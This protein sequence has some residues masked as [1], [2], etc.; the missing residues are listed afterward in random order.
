MI[1]HSIIALTL[2]AAVHATPPNIILIMADDL[3][4]GD[5]GCY[6]QKAI[7]TPRLDRMAAEG[8]KFTQF[9]AGSTVCAPSRSVLM[10]GLHTG[11]T[12]V[13]GNASK[14]AGVKGLGGAT[15]RVPLNDEDVTIAEVLK[16]AGYVTG[17]TG[18]WGLGE[19]GTSGEP[20]AQGFD[21]WFG[22][23][24]QRRAHNHY[25]DYL[26]KNRERV[27]MPE[28][29]KAEKNY[30]HDRFT[31]FALDFVRRHR[32]QPFFLYLPYCVPHDHYQLPPDDLR[33]MDRDW[34]KDEKSHAEMVTR[35]DRDVGRLLDLL[36]ELKLSERT[37]VFFC[38]DNGAAR[39]WEGRFDSS[40][41]LRGRKRDLTEGGLRSPMIVRWPG[42]VPA[43]TVST[44]PW[45]AA[46][47][48]PTCAT[49]ADVDS[50][51]GL[52]GASVVPLLTCGGN[53]LGERSFYWEFHERGFQQ[54]AR[55]GDWKAI[56]HG[57]GKPLELYHLAEDPGETKNLA[58]THPAEGGRLRDFIEGARTESKAWPQK[59]GSR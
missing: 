32:D 23:L 5:L 50:P 3:G 16:Q 24:N 34:T 31:D 56:V 51:A 52:D 48:L 53:A 12:T 22:F 29:E 59:P 46:D 15:G 35:L 17:M 47:I 20:N 1:R 44:A 6:G 18:K 37:V 21:E 25:P 58:A 57:P 43:A 55:I 8:R 2:A 10:T 19:P 28:N 41:E 49:L 26:W 39:R 42:T 54:A 4:Y 9:Y 27:P 30:S 38:S 13:R 7:E 36:D 14:H 45:W 11:H 40:G 33:Y